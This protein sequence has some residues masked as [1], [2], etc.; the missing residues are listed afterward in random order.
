MRYRPGIRSYFIIVF[1]VIFGMSIVFINNYFLNQQEE[2]KNS[3]E[4]I[5]ATKLI[6]ELRLDTSQDSLLAKEL[7][8]N[9]NTL[10]AQ[11][12]T[13]LIKVKSYSWMIISLIAFTAFFFFIFLIMKFSKPIIELQKATELIQRG[14]YDINLPEKGI[15]ELKELKKSFNTMSKELTNTQEKLVESEKQAIWKDLS[16][17][18]AH[19]IKNPLTPIQLT[20][21]RLEEKYDDKE[22]FYAYFPQ[23]TEVIH[24]E[25]QNLLSISRNFSTF[26]KLVV[27]QKSA[28]SPKETL[29]NIIESYSS[30]F[31]INT[32]FNT[33]KMTYFDQDHFYQIITNLLQNAIDA[34]QRKTPIDVSLK[35]E[36]NLLIVCIEDYGIGIERED[37][38]RIYNPYFTKKTNGSGI[39]LALVKKF[40]EA[41]GSTIFVNSQVG[42]GTKFRFSMEIYNENSDSR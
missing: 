12:K 26:A 41:N 29:L 4:N 27:P 13:T 14:F 37:I 25:I 40:I 39:G 2:I 34:S 7:H 3:Y 11:T 22:K 36:H 30:D 18:L 8:N 20:L 31:Q 1:I 17:A 28:F 32:A 19:E 21:Q 6:N 15:W 24:N 5:D 38:S 23:A 10:K 35:E 9:I 16:R 33:D 42:I